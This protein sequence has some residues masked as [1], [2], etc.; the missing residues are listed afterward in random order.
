MGEADENRLAFS[1]E[2]VSVSERRPSV[3]PGCMGIG[4]AGCPSVS[5][6]E[7]VAKRGKG[8]V[9]GWKGASMDLPCVRVSRCFGACAAACP[10]AWAYQ[11]PPGC[12]RVPVGLRGCVGVSECAAVESR[13]RERCEETRA[14]LGRQA[15]RRGTLV[16]AEDC[17]AHTQWK[18]VAAEGGARA[19]VSEMGQRTPTTAAA[20]VLYR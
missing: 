15:E 16:L 3:M 13:P 8:T 11:S 9:V 19:T 10:S 14:C 5:V 2:G 4:M 12:L 1:K 18:C 17:L 20:V 7:C 6:P